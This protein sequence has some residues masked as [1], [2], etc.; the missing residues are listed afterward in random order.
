ME[1]TRSPILLL[2]LMLNLEEMLVAIGEPVKR[3]RKKK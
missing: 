3:W 1:I 2:S